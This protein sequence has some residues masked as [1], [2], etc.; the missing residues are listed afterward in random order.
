MKNKLIKAISSFLIMVLVIGSI[1]IFKADYVS[2]TSIESKI[3][4]SLKKNKYTYSG[5]A[6]K[7]TVTVK[8]A[9]KKL[10][11]KNYTV[12]YPSGRK[13]IGKYT[14]TVKLKGMYKKKKLSGI[15][16]ISFTIVPQKPKF[17]AAT[18]TNDVSVC[19]N[20][21]LIEMNKLTGYQISYRKASATKGTKVK[22]KSNIKTISNLKSNTRYA[23]KVRSYKTVKS[24]KYYS[25]WSDELFVTT[26]KAKSSKEEKTTE[27]RTTTE[28]P[29]P[30]PTPTCSHDWK[31]VY[32]HIE[33][34]YYIDNNELLAHYSENHENEN[35]NTNKEYRMPYEEYAA[36][37]ERYKGWYCIQDGTFGPG[38]YIIPVKD[39]NG[40]YLKNHGWCSSGD[41]TEKYKF[42]DV[43]K[44][45]QY[46]HL[47]QNGKWVDDSDIC[48][49]STDYGKTIQYASIKECLKRAGCD[50]ND[51]TLFDPF[52]KDFGLI[53]ENCSY[54]TFTEV[55]YRR[56]RKEEKDVVDYYKCT[57]CGKTK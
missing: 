18:G 31:P 22:T 36:L 50:E 13:N 38:E 37:S 7:P 10:P 56:I 15:K 25:A 35:F 26:R 40:N 30:T 29:T 16:K 41:I 54:T 49:Y 46:R 19:I 51:T 6:F 9:G 55:I 24:K 3:S 57:K 21:Y 2:A 28:T 32:D 27:K 43:Y 1:E 20:R 42:Y 39:S 33:N 5:R 23:V 17:T 44:G 53:D 45:I 48:C 52:D 11:K 47:N 14:I 34:Y 8:Y 12:K 4:T